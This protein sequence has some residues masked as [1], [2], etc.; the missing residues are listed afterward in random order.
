MRLCLPT[1]I[2]KL[3]LPHMDKTEIG[4]TLNRLLGGMKNA[5]VVKQ[6]AIGGTKVTRQAIAYW[7]SGKHWPR[8][9]KLDAL[10][11]VCG[12]SPEYILFKIEKKE[13]K[14]EDIRER[15]CNDDD[16]LDLLRA[17]RATNP[18]GMTDIIA[19][20]NLIASKHPRNGKVI[21]IRHPRKGKPRPPEQ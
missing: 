21:P 13:Q 9:E 7:R 20:A 17:Y 5:E 11:K 16:E 18:E 3:E 15:I 12:R 19:M 1:A 8:L 14:L 2:V 4:R 10:A 6:L